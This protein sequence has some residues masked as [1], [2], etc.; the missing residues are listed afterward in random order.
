MAEDIHKED[1]IH[2]M[3]GVETRLEASV[4]LLTIEPNV[5]LTESEL[6]LF[7]L[8]VLSANAIGRP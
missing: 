4:V 6:P 1:A 2:P 5:V 3:D 7:L 8:T